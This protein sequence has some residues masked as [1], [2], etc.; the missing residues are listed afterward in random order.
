MITDTVAPF[1]RGRGPLFSLRSVA[2]LNEALYE[3][4]E[5]REPCVSVTSAASVSSRFAFDF[6][7]RV[8]VPL[9]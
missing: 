6:A 7:L 4:A 9:W 5:T 8:F 3:S 2:F 1:P